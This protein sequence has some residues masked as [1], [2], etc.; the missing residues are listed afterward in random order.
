[1]KKNTEKLA[2]QGTQDE[3]KQ[4]K[5]TTLYVGHHFK[6]T[7]TNNVYITINFFFNTPFNKMLMYY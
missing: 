1:M 7:N 6:Q 4:T 5:Y 3:E 2:I